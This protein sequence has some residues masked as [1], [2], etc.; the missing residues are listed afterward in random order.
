[1]LNA[2]RIYKDNPTEI[3]LGRDAFTSEAEL[4]NTIAHELN[5]ARSW[6]KGGDAPESTAYRAGDALGE[7]IEGKR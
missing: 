5:H 7:Y 2:G 3:V 6:L 4:A 1:M